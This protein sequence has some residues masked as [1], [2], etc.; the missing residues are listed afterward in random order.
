MTLT[1]V[2]SSC[3]KAVGY[4]YETETLYVQFTNGKIYEYYNVPKNVYD[5][6]M[7][8]LSR[9]NYLATRIAKAYNYSEV[10]EV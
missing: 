10:Q 6:M 2:P 7:T 3:L 8:A 9:G 4:D 5:E 1:P